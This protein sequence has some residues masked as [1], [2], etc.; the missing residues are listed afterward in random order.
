MKR[1][2]VTIITLIGIAGGVSRPVAAQE[3]LAAAKDLYAAAA[4]EDAL[5]VLAR[6]EDPQQKTQNAKYQVFCLIA[7][8]RHAEAAGV[9]ERM[10]EADPLFTPDREEASPR[11]Q[12][13]FEKVRAQI[14]PRLARTLYTDAK[15][16]F[17]RKEHDAA[18]KKF[19]LLLQ[20]I[21]RAGAAEDTLLGEFKVL[22]GGFLDLAR[23]ASTSNPKAAPTPSSPAAS[24]PPPAPA[25]SPVAEGGSTLTPP[26]PIV[27]QFPPWNPVG[28]IGRG[29]Q[30]HGMIRLRISAAGTVEAAELADPVH[31]A[32]DQLLLRAAAKWKYKPGLR[33]GVPVQSERVVAVHLKQD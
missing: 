9:I 2:A 18:L 28:F 24:A 33:G 20:I 27:E 7:L 25:P 10:L 26:V 14:A 3:T 6:I 21:E 29:Q 12:E 19:E 5:K 11:V 31:P 15:A 22:A 32:Y 1:W 30:F 4:Y 8:D 16:A 23:A 13:T 17:E